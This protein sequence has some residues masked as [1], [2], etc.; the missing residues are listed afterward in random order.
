MAGNAGEWVFDW[1]DHDYYKKGPKKNPIGPTKVMGR[2][3]GASPCC[4]FLSFCVPYTGLMLN[5]RT[6][7][8]GMGSVARGYRNPCRVECSLLENS[9]SAHRTQHFSAYPYS[10]LGKRIVHIVSFLSSLSTVIEHAR[11][12]CVLQRLGGLYPGRIC[13]QDPSCALNDD[14]KS[15]PRL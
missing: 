5:R 12:T 2:W 15:P 3:S 8:L 6:G 4:T 11:E 9:G 10:L 7:S 13:T 14:P 1:Y